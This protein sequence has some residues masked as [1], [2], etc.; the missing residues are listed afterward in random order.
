MD[1]SNILF[2]E[3][4]SPK[5]DNC[6]KSRIYDDCIILREQS[7][8]SDMIILLDT[9]NRHMY[10]RG[11]STQ[12]PSG[13]DHGNWKTIYLDLEIDTSLIKRVEDVYCIGPYV[14]VY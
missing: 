5:C 13:L 9:E 4:P 3:C 2:V 1:E 14:V 10:I 11:I 7:E 8:I 6:P 12:Y